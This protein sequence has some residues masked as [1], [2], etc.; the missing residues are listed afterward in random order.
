MCKFR[1]EEEIVSSNAKQEQS[2]GEMEKSIE[3]QEQR[4]KRQGKC[5]DQIR[6]SMAQLVVM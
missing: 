5:I 4:M 6:N 1:Q 3:K 2:I